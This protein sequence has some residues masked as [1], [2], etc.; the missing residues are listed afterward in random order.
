MAKKFV[1]NAIQ[2]D[3]ETVH[4]KLLEHMNCEEST[5]NIIIQRFILINNLIKLV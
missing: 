5:S 2:Q 4:E 3:I 1:M